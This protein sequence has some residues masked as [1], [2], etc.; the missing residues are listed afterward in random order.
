MKFTKFAALLLT[1]ILCLAPVSALAATEDDA[2]ALM[3]EAGIGEAVADSDNLMGMSLK[4]VRYDNDGDVYVQWAFANDMMRSNLG[5]AYSRVRFFDPADLATPRAAYTT[6]DDGTV[7]LT[8]KEGDMINVLD[9]VHLSKETIDPESGVIFMYF[10]GSG[11]GAPEEIFTLPL[12]FILYM[13]DDGVHAL[14]DTPRYASQAMIDAF[15]AQ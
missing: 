11:E 12:A 1:L 13:D 3:A 10:D 14:E 15:N 5:Y 6:N 2:R 9:F 4:E 8:F 7:N